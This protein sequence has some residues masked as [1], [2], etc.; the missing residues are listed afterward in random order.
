MNLPIAV[1]A[2]LIVTDIVGVAFG[3]YGYGMCK[4][5]SWVDVALPVGRVAF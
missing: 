5:W 2:L 3:L 4:G 1:I